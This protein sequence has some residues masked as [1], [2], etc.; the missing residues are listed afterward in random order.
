MRGVELIN[1]LRGKKEGKYGRMGRGGLTNLVNH[2]RHQTLHLI[3][4]NHPTFAVTTTSKPHRSHKLLQW[5][6]RPS[7]PSFT[8]FALLEPACDEH[9]AEEIPQRNVASAL[10]SEVDAPFDEFV[11]AGEQRG[12]EPGQVAAPDAGA[13]WGEEGVQLWI[14]LE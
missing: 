11:L 6:S 8:L 7:N 12:V 2:I 9:F 5:N 14:G 1:V 13:Q 3:P 10:Q 4:F